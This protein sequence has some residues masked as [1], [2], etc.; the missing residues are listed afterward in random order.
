M[1]FLLR[2]PNCGSRT[3]EEFVYGEIP[4]VPDSITDENE[5]DLDFAFM[6]NNPRG[7]TNERWFHVFGCRRWFT[8]ERHTVTN[9]VRYRSP[10]SSSNTS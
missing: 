1:A 3:I 10:K 2:C 9:E 8:V 4:R 6:R 5:R 7:W